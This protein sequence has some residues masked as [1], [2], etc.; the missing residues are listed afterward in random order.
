MIKK[1]KNSFKNRKIKKAQKKEYFRSLK[2]AYDNSVLSWQ[3][4]EHLHHERGP[5]WKVFMSL[6]VVITSGIAI[7]LGQW[8]FAIAILTAAVVYLLIHQDSEKD[9][10]VTISDI[11]VK[12]GNRKYPFSRIK[13]FW[14]IYEPPY[15]QNLYIRV[16][17][18]IALDIAI[19]LG[20][21]D[22]STIRDFMIEKV[23]EMAG[24]KE[25]IT[26]VFLK[27]FKL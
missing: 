22:P 8:S 12:V 2:T 15:T 11:G 26:D 9:V 25:S 5:F 24:V 20:D 10:E 27:L 14:I 7:Y 17:D 21:M 13:S 19:N 1:I 6:A 3:T 18:D 16:A 23:P 4:Q